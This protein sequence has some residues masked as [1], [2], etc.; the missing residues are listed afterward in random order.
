MHGLTR[1]SKSRSTPCTALLILLLGALLSGA[2]GAADWIYVVKPGDNPWD[3]TARYL[4]GLRYWPRIQALNGITSPTTIPP[5]TPLRI[6]LA[7]LRARPALAKVAALEGQG[8]VA[9]AGLEH[10]LVVGMQLATGAE[11]HTSTNANVTLEFGDGS[12]L[13]LLAESVLR[14]VLLQ[15]FENTGFYQTRVHLEQGHTENVVRPFGGGPGRFEISTPAATTA[16]R[17]T[18]Y[19]V[20][21]GADAARTEVLSGK[22]GVGTAA[23][24]IDVASGFGTVTPLKG[25]PTPPVTLLA[26]PDITTLPVVVE[27]VPLA[28]KL[29]PLAKAH[30]YRLQLARDKGFAALV[31]DGTSP[32]ELL[33]GP[34]LPDG[35]YVARVRALDANGLEG[36]NAEQSFV[37]NARPEPPV[38]V[39]PA[40]G[41]GVTAEQPAFAWAERAEITRYHLQLARD[42]GFKIL[43]V[44]DDQ[45][46]AASSTAAPPL[47]PGKYYWRVAAIDA[48]EG[49]GP[50]SDTQ[51]FRRVPPG[52]TIEPPA[53]D[54]KQMTLRWRAGLPGQQSQVQLANN[55]KFDPLVLD[56]HT[57][58][59]EITLPR[60]PGGTYF[61]RT[62]TLDTD[63][64]EGPF[65]TPQH[66]EV[67]AARGQWWLLLLPLVPFLAL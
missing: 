47:A 55:E 31:F 46:T 61:I 5:A 18:D 57:A 48:H 60:P 7:W 41:A 59:A 44:D 4:N 22:V 30:G 43:L 51:D 56:T 37:L 24:T 50:F 27:R 8:S 53:F 28:F 33:H 26:P 2:V 13:L 38:I 32:S 19:R 63:G 62:R 29:V 66:I 58:A 10:P 35:D 45:V 65:G 16:V 52:P 15:T 23:A 54:A 49:A 40:P 14:L 11:I 39:A 9:V 1:T 34:D 20:H 3:L 25:A 6:P 12:R 36:R 42:P 21:A 17:G 64:F 67:P